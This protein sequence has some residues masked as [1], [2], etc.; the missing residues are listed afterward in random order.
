MICRY[1][2]NVVF[3]GSCLKALKDGTLAA[4]VCSQKHDWVLLPPLSQDPKERRDEYN[5]MV[6]EEDHW[7]SLHEFKRTLQMKWGITSKS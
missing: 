7:I 6:F 2:H 4:N 1:C 5:D 3:C